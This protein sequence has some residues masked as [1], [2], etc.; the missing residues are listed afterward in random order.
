[1]IIGMTGFGGA[2]R[3]L[4][5]IK[6]IIEL[7][8]QNHRYLDMVFFLPVGY[9]SLESKIRDILVK[10]IQRGRVTISIKIIDKNPHH[11]HFNRELA[12]EY[13]RYAEDI[14][15]DFHL[16][17]NLGVADLFRL[18]GVFETREA[19]LSPE[20]IWPEI[21]VGINLSLRSL[22]SMRKREGR[23]LAADLRNVLKRMSIQIK[24]IESRSKFLLCDKKKD[25]TTEEFLSFQ[26]SCDINE[27]LARLKHYV[28][29]FKLLINSSTVVGKKLDFVAQEMQRETNTIGSK[30]Q[31]QVV[32]NSVIALKSKIE[33]L[34]EQAQNVE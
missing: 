3:S 7:K 2:E 24:K 15:K 16:I 26:K 11:L 31:D 34:R 12:K 1:M 5:K 29:E 25:A 20:E 13:L 23:S 21:Q 8:S 4:G 6:V 33:K 22:F 28:E 9:S 10:D 32:S 30:V 27:E 14:K 19:V 18:P 17:N